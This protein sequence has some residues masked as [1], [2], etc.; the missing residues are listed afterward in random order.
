MQRL[1][2]L[3]LLI[4][5][6]G[7]SGGAWYLWDKDTGLLITPAGRYPVA[8]GVAL[9][10]LTVFASLLIRRELPTKDALCDTRIWSL[11][12][13]GI[14]LSDW[15]TRP[16]GFFKGSSIRGE[17]FVGFVLSYLLLKKGQ[18]VRFF[19]L[20]PLIVVVLLAWSFKIA[21]NGA[22]LFS[23]D[24]AM[25]L[26]RLKL[27]KEN[28]PNIPFWSPLWNAG[29]DARDFFATG[30]LNVFILFSP[31]IYL[32][33]VEQ[34]YSFIVAVL[35]WIITPL[36]V[37]SSSRLLSLSKKGSAIATTLALC[38]SLFWYRWSLKYG[39]VGFITSTALFPLVFALSVRLL[40]TDLPK[41]RTIIFFA[42][43][44][45]LMLLWSP[46]GLALIPLVAL[47]LNRA[48]TLIFSRRHILTALLILAIN[49]PWM[50]IMWKVSNLG[51]FL[52]SEQTAS[53]AAPT[54]ISSEGDSGNITAPL[55]QPPPSNG[56]IYRHGR[57]Q[58]NLKKALNNWHNNANSLNPLILI[59]AIPAIIIFPGLGKRYLVGTSI[60]LV[61]LGT[62][63]VSIKPQLELDR[64]VVMA[65]I[66]A[67]IPIG[68]LI[69]QAILSANRGNTWRLS[70]ATIC[71]FLLIGPFAATS[72]VLNRS[73]DTYSFMSS[74][75]I[76]LRDVIA[77]NS[78][79]G[80]AFFSGCVLHEL[81][82]GHLAPLAIW[83]NIPM[84]AT[85]YAHNIWWYTQPIPQN[86]LQRGDQG[87]RDFLDGI[88][89]TL[90]LAHEPAWIE[91]LKKRPAEYK[92]IWRGESFFAF[93]RISY[94]SN[95]ALSGSL[96]DMEFSTNSA[97]FTPLSEAVTVKLKYLPFLEAS[98]CKV[99][100]APSNLGFDL[101]S[102]SECIP[103][104][105]VTLTSASPLKRLFGG[106]AS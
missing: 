105:S 2:S 15:V 13:V 74:E 26:F 80:R 11:G 10:I 28:F 77:N 96:S 59:L 34:V 33:N 63:G 6:L 81:S 103:G 14:Y 25:F 55:P 60:W 98:G 69:A 71:S 5:V 45:S 53:L 44:S 57:G 9:L 23:D 99:A 79:G 30:A 102:L 24:H 87:V 68:H 75:A 65:S 17:I 16:W 51:H 58:F 35:L 40:H 106:G 18:A 62:V 100:P 1:G 47:A 46:S 93:K 73:D 76:E 67:T 97:T 43:V 90:V 91:Y 72:I 4:I 56:T 83:T 95:Y 84:Y 19:T 82:G 38:S 48:P 22:L 8:L 89:A 101:I 54:P 49:L 85:S 52:N 20:W 64:M 50:A 88:N 94:T 42:L 37:F 32:F 78:A 39:T 86:Q 21:S 7:V 27:L 61:G 66:L 29:F 12:L 3:A 41:W 36:S 31:I 104:A 70:A 92:Q